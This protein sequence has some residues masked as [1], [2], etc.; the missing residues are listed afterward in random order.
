MDMHAVAGVVGPV[1]ANGKVSVTNHATRIPIPKV[2]MPY[3][4]F[5]GS[6]NSGFHAAPNPG[7]SAAIIYG[8]NNRVLCIIPFL[9]ANTSTSGMPTLN[10]GE[11]GQ[12]HKDGRI[13]D[14][15]PNS[16][17]ATLYADPTHSM[18]FTATATQFIM[19][20]TLSLVNL[21]VSGTLSVTGLLTAVNLTLTGLL[22]A[23]N[24]TASGTLGVSGLSTLSGGATMGA[25]IT[26]GGN[27]ISGATTVNTANLIATSNVFGGA[28]NPNSGNRFPFSNCAVQTSAPG[29]GGAVA[30]P[31]T[32]TGYLFI[33]ISGTNRLLPYY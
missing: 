19:N 27:N 10:P 29:G 20:L 21:V 32:P 23:V 12:Y 33:S 16:G 13:A 15:L 8:P 1:K 5:T 22:T 26:M 6:R 18:S 11:S 24:I 3:R 9:D 2:T 14:V 17:G 28:Y 25:G 4:S 7:D 31:A 30:P